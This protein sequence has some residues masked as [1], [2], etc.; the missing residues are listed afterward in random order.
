MQAIGALE[1]K[2]GPALSQAM[3]AMA[4]AEEQFGRAEDAKQWREKAR[5]ICCEPRPI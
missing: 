5:D 2:P 3:E 4:R 1:R